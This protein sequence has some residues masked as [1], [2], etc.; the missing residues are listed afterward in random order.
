MR[1][2]MNSLYNMDCMIAL[3]ELP[4]LSFNLALVDPPYGIGRF[5]SLVNMPEHKDKADIN[6]WDVKPPP[7]YF[8]ELFRISEHQIIFGA[9]NFRLPETEYFIV[10]DKMQAVENFASAEFAW[11]N[12]KKPAKVFRYSINKLIQDRRSEGGKIHPTQKPVELYRW[13]LKNYATPGD[14]VIDTH[15]GSGSS[16][17]ACHDMGFA[18]LGFEINEFYYEKALK[19]IENN[20]RQ[21]TIWDCQKG[22]K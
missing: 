12:Y 6:K 9:N 7:E 2:E 11:T 14:T 3:R 1:F 18:Y 16:L 15:V 5:G 8:K 4:D 17:M 21:V 13:I 19:R 10:W 22:H 20:K